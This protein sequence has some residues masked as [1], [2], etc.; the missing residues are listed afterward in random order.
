LAVDRYLK[1]AVSRPGVLKIYQS[2]GSLPFQALEGRVRGVGL[3]SEGD[4]LL[5]PGKRCLLFL[6]KPDDSPT[7]RRLGYLSG[8]VDG[9]TGKVGELDE[10][11]LTDPGR[12]R[13]VIEAGILRSQSGT[14]TPSELRLTGNQLVGLREEEAV[15]RIEKLVSPRLKQ[16]SAVSPS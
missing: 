1:G 14:G 8:T 2:G 3:A 4:P 9:V 5:E 12:G 13:Y 7:S 15:E 11:R 6:R 16:P 10:L